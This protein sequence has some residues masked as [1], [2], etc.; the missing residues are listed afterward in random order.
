[1]QVPVGP[2]LDVVTVPVS[3]LRKGPAGDHVFVLAEQD[4]KTRAQLRVVHSSTMLGDDVVILD[5]LK[6]GERV[7]AAGSFKLYPFALVNVKDEN[8]AAPGTS[9]N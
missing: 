2:K 9:R 8:G 1:M 5:G 4:G 3:A 7:A 6:A